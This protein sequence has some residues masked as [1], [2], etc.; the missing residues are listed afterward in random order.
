MLVQIQLVLLMVILKGVISVWECELCA[1]AGSGA[2]P[3]PQGVRHVAPIVVSIPYVLYQTKPHHMYY[4]KLY[5]TIPNHKMQA[6][7][8]HTILSFKV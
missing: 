7:L 8:N 1:S 3:G 5:Q 2:G 4:T 6:T